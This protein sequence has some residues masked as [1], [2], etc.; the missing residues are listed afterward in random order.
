MPTP[1]EVA[2]AAQRAQA[3]LRIDDVFLVETTCVVDRALIPNQVLPE[4]ACKHV[5]S[6]DREAIKQARQLNDD[7]GTT[8]HIVR[9]FVR[10]GVQMLKPGVQAPSPPEAPA[11]DDVLGELTHC[12]A[13]D[14]VCAENF[15]N[16]GQ[17]I[18]AFTRNVIHHAWPFWREAVMRECERH[19]LPRVVIPMLQPGAMPPSPLSLPKT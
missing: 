12:F 9:Y 1:E 5:L 7:A 17:A 14:Y 3:S 8:V 4:L 6:I 19:R 16:D 18:G 2:K 10:G 15:L 13:V 11:A